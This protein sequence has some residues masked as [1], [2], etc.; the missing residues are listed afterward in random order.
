[1]VYL[2]ILWRSGQGG[3][4]GIVSIPSVGHDSIRDSYISSSHRD[5]CSLMSHEPYR[6][7]LCAVRS[8]QSPLALG[9]RIPVS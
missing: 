5:D 7:S 9:I 4:G 2:R 3:G 8:R 6:A 1:V